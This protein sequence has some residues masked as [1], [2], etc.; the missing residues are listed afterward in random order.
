MIRITEN[1]FAPIELETLPVDRQT[2]PRACSRNREAWPLSR[3]T[4]ADM[5]AE[6]PVMQG[7]FADGGDAL[8]LGLCRWRSVGYFRRCRNA[9]AAIGI[10][11]NSVS[12]GSDQPVY[13]RDSWISLNQLGLALVRVLGKDQSSSDTFNMRRNRLACSLNFRADDAEDHSMLGDPE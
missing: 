5:D 6:L 13:R 3:Q 9:A 4:Q 2:R 12:Y 1:S 10:S 7:G 11:D 8:I